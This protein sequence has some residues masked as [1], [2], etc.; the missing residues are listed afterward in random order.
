MGRWRTKD[1][2]GAI[3]ATGM[4]ANGQSFTGLKGL[5]QLLNSNPEIF[6]SATV[7]RMM[8]YALGR[9]VDPREMPAVRAIVRKAA[10]GYKFDDIV[11]GVVT[12]VPFTMK[13]ATGSQS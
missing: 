1:Q 3:D 7:S 8:T 13:T 6:V 5:K 9:P 10:P 4:L 12:S 2:G 11:L